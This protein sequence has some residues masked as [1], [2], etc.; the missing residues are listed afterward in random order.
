LIL[1][2]ASLFSSS[3]W[4]RRVD[5]LVG[6]TRAHPQ[7]GAVKK[8]KSKKRNKKNTQKKQKQKKS[9]KKDN[10]KKKEHKKKKKKKQAFLA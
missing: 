4:P 1:R 8:R 6:T 7:L 5:Y 2:R 10:K 9:K 3:R